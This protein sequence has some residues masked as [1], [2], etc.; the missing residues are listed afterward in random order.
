MTKQPEPPVLMPIEDAPNWEDIYLFDKNGKLLS[1]HAYRLNEKTCEPQEFYREKVG[2]P[3]P[4]YGDIRFGSWVKKEVKKAAQFM[5]APKPAKPV[6]SW[7]PYQDKFG[8]FEGN[9]VHITS[10]SNIHKDDK[11]MKDALAEVRAA[12]DYA[13]NFYPIQQDNE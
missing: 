8:D 5:L 3:E 7:E 13:N 2:D 6:H 12:I 10:P 11:A 9:Y 4:A 1:K